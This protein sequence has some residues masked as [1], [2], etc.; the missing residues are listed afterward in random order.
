ML[1]YT[2]LTI[3]PKSQVAAFIDTV[4]TAWLGY[5]AVIWVGT[6]STGAELDSATA[7]LAA[8]GNLINAGK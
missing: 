5:D 4:A 1:V 8:G 2:W 7:Y 3:C 6:T